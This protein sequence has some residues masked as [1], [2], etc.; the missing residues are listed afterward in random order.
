MLDQCFSIKLVYVAI[1]IQLLLL[2]VPKNSQPSKNFSQL[3][4][5]A[6]AMITTTGGSS[7]R[8][9]LDFTEQFHSEI[10]SLAKVNLCYIDPMQ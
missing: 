8:F 7:L 6:Y 4:L 3:E 10:C 2:P 1:S 5:C 9:M